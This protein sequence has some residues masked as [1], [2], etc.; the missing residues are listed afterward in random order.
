MLFENLVPTLS[1]T[2][3]GVVDHLFAL[4]H[5]FDEPFF[6]PPSATPAAPYSPALDVRQTKDSFQ[7]RAE[8][9]GLEIADLKLDLE[10]DT[11]TIRGEKRAESS[12]STD[13]FQWSE[14]RSGSFTRS[15]RLGTPVVA[16]AVKAHLRNG[17]L[18]VELPKC[19][20]ARPRTIPIQCQPKLAAA[21][22]PERAIETSSAA[23]AMASSKSCTEVS[24]S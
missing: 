6:G 20:T 5:V 2:R 24:S 1:K 15:V 4:D 3:T 19:E 8:V 7:V 16:S 21:S 18:T 12:E 22:A 10:N 14:S 11:L 13:G 23:S 9:P 17:V